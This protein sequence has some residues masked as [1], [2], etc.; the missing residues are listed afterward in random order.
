MDGQSP[1]APVTNQADL[2][3]I[4]NRL[5]VRGEEHDGGWEWTLS[6]GGLVSA[7]V[8]VLREGN[9][10]WIGW[11]GMAGDTHAAPATHE[12]IELVPVAITQEEYE[13]FYLGF[14]NAT[15]WPLYHDAIRPATFDRSWW[16]AYV[17]VN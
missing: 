15:L 8:P 9:G 11:A 4:A 3:V 2:I 1:H 13:E 6:P 17:T 10:L 16:H 12:G 14:A 7:L 5:P